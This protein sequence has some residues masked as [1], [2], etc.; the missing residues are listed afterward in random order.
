MAEIGTEKM[1]QVGAT[2]WH[3]YTLSI[4]GGGGGGGEKQEK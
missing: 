3:D 1:R 2:V 4:W